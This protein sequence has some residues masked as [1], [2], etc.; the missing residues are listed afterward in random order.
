MKKLLVYLPLAVVLTACVTNARPPVRA[1]A[2]APAEVE[3]PPQAQAESPDPAAVQEQADAP[4]Q[5]QAAD[6][7]PA[8][9][10][11]AKAQAIAY[12]KAETRAAYMA[13]AE[14]AQAAKPPAQKKDWRDSMEEAYPRG[15]SPSPS[16]TST[17]KAAYLA[18]AG[19]FL[20]GDLFAKAKERAKKKAE[21]EERE[22]KIQPQLEKL[23]AAAW[24]A[25]LREHK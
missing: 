17:E 7:D 12:C 24:Q 5:G 18:T 22:K 13:K 19:V 4:E 2:P 21:R 8:Q 10:E 23:C 20:V 3:A 16:S 15:T 11:A 14:Q 6:P 9:M 25:V 1:D